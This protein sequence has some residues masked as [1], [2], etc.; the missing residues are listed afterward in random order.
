MEDEKPTGETEPA[1]PPP[2]QWERRT[3]FKINDRMRD[4]VE[5]T[6]DVTR[7]EIV[8]LRRKIEKLQYGS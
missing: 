3:S 7:G 6:I 5:Q 4:V 8:K 2:P 1:K